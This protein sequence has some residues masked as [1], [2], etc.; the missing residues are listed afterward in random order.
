[1]RKHK[2]TAV[3]SVEIKQA[4]L[5]S[6]ASTTPSIAENHEG[7]SNDDGSSSDRSSFTLPSD[8]EEGLSTSKP[9]LRVTVKVI[10]PEG[11]TALGWNNTSGRKAAPIFSAMASSSMVQSILS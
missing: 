3:Y 11:A 5:T 8:L 10:N 7:D 2:A 9:I 1:M 6:S 4:A